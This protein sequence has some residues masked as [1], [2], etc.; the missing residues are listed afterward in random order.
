[1]RFFLILLFLLGTQSSSFAQQP[2]I[3]INEFMASNVSSYADMEDFS[4]FS[5]WIE[6]YNNESEPI[7]ISGF[8]ITDNLA[9]PTKWQ[10]PANT[11]IPAK[12]YYLIWADGFDDVP[13]QDYIRSWWPY[14]IQ[15]TTQFGHA[16]FK[17]SKE[18]EAIGFYNTSGV[19]IDT[20]EYTSQIEDVSYGR[21]PDGADNWFYFGE[22]TPENSNTTEG[23][24]TTISAKEVIFSTNGGFY[25]SFFLLELSSSNGEGIVRYTLDGSEPTSNSPQY[26]D[27]ISISENSILTA[28][29]FES[30]K[31]PGIVSSNSYFI[32]ETRH[33]PAFSIIS[34]SEYLMGSDKGIY[35][36]TYKERE[37][38]INFEFYPL[39]EEGFS[40][41]AG[42]R[43]G[44]ENI[45]RFA[46]K[47]LNI[48]ARGDYG[49]SVIEYQ[50]FDHLPY[51]A[52][53]RLY[54]RNSGD[55][56]PSTMI[57][58][59]MIASLLRGEISNSTQAYRP[60][61]LYLNG[62]YWGLYNLRE[63]LDKQYF[64]LH[65][66]TAEVDLDHLESTNTVIEGDATD[67]INLTNYANSND[68]SD[69]VHYQNVISQIDVENL[70]DFVI[71]QAFLANSSWGHNREVWRDGGGD[72]KWRWVLVDMDRGFNTSRI[73]SNQINDIYTNLK[74]FGAL[75]A[76]N[77]FRN[78][79][80][81]RYSERLN[82]TFTP[83]RIIGI[84]DSLQA[85]IAP[86]MPR[87]IEKWGTYI[88]SLSIDH[89][90]ES[91][92]VSSMTSWNSEVEKYRT[93]SNQRSENAILHL[94]S[95][96]GLSERVN[97]TVKSNLNDE[98]KVDIND[99]FKDIGS[100]GEYFS[101]IPLKL[102]AYAPPGYEF[103]SWA[104]S[105][106]PSSKKTLVSKKSTWSYFDE[107]SEPDGDWKSPGFNDNSWEQGSGILG[108]GDSQ[109]T[110]INS[111]SGSGNNLITSYYRHSF[112]VEDVT[113][114]I[115]LELGLLRDDGAVVY[116]NGIEIVRSNMPE[117]TISNTTEASSTVNGS[118]ESTYEIFNLSKSNLVKGTNVISVE[119]HQISPSSSDV[120][121]DLELSAE[122]SI[123]ESEE[124]TFFTEEIEIELDSST[125]LM[126]EFEES[127]SSFVPQTIS[128]TVSL[129]LENSPYFVNDNIVIEQGGVLEIEAGVELQI[130]EGKGIYVNGELSMKGSVDQPIRLVSFYPDQ[131]WNGVFFDSANR[132]SDLEYVKIAQARGLEND[133]NFF[134][135]VS[136]LNSTVN[137]FE[138]HIDNVRLPISSQFSDMRIE[139]STISNVTMIGDYLNVNGGNLWVL[140]SVFEGNNIEDMDA[141]DIGLMKGTT[142]IDGN[143]FRDFVGDN[144]DG[145]DVGDASKNVQITNNFVINCGDKA[146]S[147]GQGSEAYVAY[148]VFANCNLG[149][150]IKDAGSI[151][152]IVNNTFYKNNVGV[153][154]FEKV[155]NRGGGTANI[156][157]S[158]FGNSQIASYTKDEFSSISTSYSISDT[159]E[160]EGAG[161]IF[162]DIKLINPEYGV[163]YPQIVSP[164]LG[165]GDPTT[166][167]DGAGSPV[168]IGALDYRGVSESTLVINEINYNSSDSFDSGDWVEFINSTKN[169][170]DISDWT[171]IDDTHTQTFSFNKATI[172]GPKEL[173]VIVKE[174]DKFMSLYPNTDVQS[175]TMNTGLSGSGESIYLY[176]D[177]GFL[178]DSL[179]YDDSSPWPEAA[180][181]DGSSLELVN[182]N[183]DNN[184]PDSWR[185]SSN[186]GTPGEINSVFVVS[187]EEENGVI[188]DKL[189]LSQNYPNPFNPSTIIQYQLN[190]QTEVTLEI[191]DLLG[192]KVAVLIDGDRKVAGTHQ[193]VFEAS[194][195]SSGI[196][197][198]KLETKDKALYKKMTLIK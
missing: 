180:D 90:G 26:S 131:E 109:T 73:S 156:K 183:L 51:Q 166:L 191:F 110:E 198:Y 35:R 159:D 179:S 20:F 119:V 68:L 50:M 42:M 145:I 24:N 9:N 171:F 15:F 77:E 103:K 160:M 27:P 127:S 43:I 101:N 134:A 55:D 14:N 161:N 28:R 106:E 143:I 85:Q 114:I 196:Y 152:E 128:N 118:G 157:N 30:G 185:A 66:S 162:G 120:S 49:E 19:L 31:L 12:G 40:M 173:I 11:I 36:N 174:S 130:D 169:D 125:E 3:Y 4:D 167:V 141:I 111:G 18:G 29:V 69:P 151:G 132:E 148:N 121:F 46:Q 95:Q 44:G 87:H 158:I 194:T 100:S 188:P 176:N 7:D 82:T 63:K 81:Q 163:F 190:E 74:I 172:L 71:V 22:P 92:G 149:V 165:A 197:I 88:D 124:L 93:F 123:Q 105:S 113:T 21:K 1:M 126:I 54:L 170:L 182:S 75:T 67:F 58:D 146:V 86:E 177:K 97:L 62:E 32:N 168:N 104:L 186:T 5:D 10:I 91:S 107:S 37:I 80:V 117:G 99:F 45:F 56:W 135:A 181:G 83:N 89:W 13:N 78:K 65:Y 116:L 139:N 187:I 154:V 98:G 115:D 112:F 39:E 17:L 52:Y 34:E 164:V 79:F 140:N 195:L 59:G 184:I 2:A 38:P 137:L 108:Y 61:V 53:K 76:N 47:P 84:V 192:R 193:V 94:S 133:E 96:F 147:I 72:N 8:Y 41:G 25:E 33:L 189:G 178:V 60:S 48:Y 57:R 16:N 6:L 155:L 122:L 129:S 144:T 102:K 64:S 136:A 138:V 70:M 153:A 175:D 150:G 142:V 23:V